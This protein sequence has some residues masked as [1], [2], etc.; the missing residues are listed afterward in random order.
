MEA[1]ILVHLKAQLQHSAENKSTN[2]NILASY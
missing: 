1:N 2:D